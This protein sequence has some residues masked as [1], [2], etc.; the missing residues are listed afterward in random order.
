M[1]YKT[2][3]S[4]YNH[5]GQK[6]YDNRKKA[7]N[8]VTEL[9]AVLELIGEIKGKK[10]LDMGCGLGKHAKEFIKRGAD[11]VGYDA[12]EKMVKLTK[13]YCSGKGKF[14]RSTHEAVSFD[15]DSFDI[16]VSSFSI[17]YSKNLE[18][19]FNKVQLWLKKEGL[20]VFSIPHAA[21]LLTHSKDMDYSK[22][23]KIWIHINTYDLDIF[24]YYHTLDEYIQLINKYNFK[25]I[26]LLETTISKKYHGW[27]EKKYRIPNAYIFKLQ[28]A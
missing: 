10:V 18:T 3:R 25:L 7:T 11:V 6:Y 21:W 22:A 20:F 1:R 28:K 5:I 4:L 2:S 16:C 19:I 8:D 12:S 14:F 27:P 26:N 13:T 23:H 24:N 9:P 15:K 17:N